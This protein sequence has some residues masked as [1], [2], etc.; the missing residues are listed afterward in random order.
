MRTLN[1]LIFICLLSACKTEEKVIE[2]PKYLRW[3][4]DIEQDLTK[5]AKQF[6]LCNTEAEAF[7]YFNTH[8]GFRYK[9]EKK[10]LVETFNK[11]YR[12]LNGKKQ[13]GWIRIRF[14][15]NCKGEAGRF[16]VIQSNEN[17]EEFEFDKKVVEQ[18]LKITKSLKGWETLEHKGTAIDYYLYLIFKLEDGTIKEILP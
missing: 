7:Q 1:I 17:Y 8:K 3:V 9:G 6:E 14:I 16:R 12:P 10:A 15:V 13:N 2:K 18:L 5:D 11:K 4:G